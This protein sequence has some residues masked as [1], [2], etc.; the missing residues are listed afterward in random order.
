MIANTIF[1][2]TLTSVIPRNAP[3]VSPQAALNAGSGADAVR[4]LVPAGGEGELVGILR[5][6]SESLRNVFYFL[7]GIS[8]LAALMSLGMGWKDVR[9]KKHE[10][11]MD[12]TPDEALEEN[13][14]A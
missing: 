4:S 13:K 7:V 14:A 3:S 2:Q 9:S 12:K 11:T 10:E 5:A 6:Y 8:A 1:S